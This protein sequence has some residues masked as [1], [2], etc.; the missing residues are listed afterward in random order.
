MVQCILRTF[1]YYRSYSK[2]S[3]GRRGLV[4]FGQPLVGVIGLKR[5]MKG[6]VLLSQTCQR[7]GTEIL[8]K[9]LAFF[10][11]FWQVQ[12]SKTFHIGKK[13]AKKVSLEMPYLTT[14]FWLVSCQFGKLL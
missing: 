10:L 2:S 8:K 4:W 7:S 1:R 3:V 13:L 11:L 12:I 6:Q 14:L 9:R 5:Q